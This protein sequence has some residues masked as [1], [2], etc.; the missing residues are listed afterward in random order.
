MGQVV[1]GGIIVNGSNGGSIIP[2]CDI[3]RKTG[4]AV[5]VA[6]TTIA[7]ATAFSTTDYTIDIRCYD[8]G[9]NNV[10]FTI[11]TKTV[12]GFKVTPVINSTIDYTCIKE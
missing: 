11:T 4:V 8:A 12:N 7:F 10:D 5:L 1:N 6:G 2:S 9:G 3:K